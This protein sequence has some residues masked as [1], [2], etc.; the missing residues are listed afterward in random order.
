VGVYSDAGGHPGTLLSDGYR[1]SLMLGAWNAVA[2]SSAHLE[3]GAPYW[4]ALA[5]EGGTLRYRSR[6]HGSCPQTPSIPIHSLKLPARWSAHGARSRAGCPISAYVGGSTAS[7]C[8][9]DPEACGY[10]GPNDTGVVNCSGLTPS[11]PKTITSPETIENEDIKGNVKVFAANVTLRH[12]CV[13]DNGGERERTSAISLAEGANNFHISDSTV[14]GL[15]TTS[16]SVEEALQNNYSDP[17]A[18]ATDVKLENCAE[19]LHQLWTLNES[20]VISNGRQRADENG[21]AHTEDWWSDRNPIDANDDTLLNPSKQ[22]ATIF[23]ESGGSACDVKEKVTN[24]LIAGGGYTLYVCANSSGNA[25]S[26]A[27]FHDDRF[28]RRVCAKKE[29]G[30]LEGRG[31]YECEGPPN[32]TSNY[33]EA[34]AGADGYYPRGGFFGLWDV[35]GETYPTSWVGSYWDDNLQAVQG[36]AHGK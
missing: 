12:D 13:E 28:A 30:D 14:R 23:S 20:Y 26:N 9:A 10:P 34:G 36:S 25:G 21:T 35:G 24:S 27:E 19:C 2:V 17:G 22:T 16:E 4:L 7:G 8:L 31:G 1:P 6:L 32:E 11:G 3:A 15:N 18:T 29:I 5:G 33:F